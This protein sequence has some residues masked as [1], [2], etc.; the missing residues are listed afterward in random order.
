MT[1]PNQGR[2]EPKIQNLA[3][4]SDEGALVEAGAV[5][6]ARQQGEAVQDYHYDDAKAALAPALALLAERTRE[7]DEVS[8]AADVLAET[9]ANLLTDKGV[10]AVKIIEAQEWWA[11]YGRAFNAACD[12]A[13]DKGREYKTAMP[14]A[15]L[16]EKP[17]ATSTPGAAPP[18]DV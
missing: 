1:Q 18:S 2:S 15:W 3:P 7:R 9:V 8:A 13:W 6:I 5:A 16:R 4:S 12:W 10:L 17:P 14:P 11:K